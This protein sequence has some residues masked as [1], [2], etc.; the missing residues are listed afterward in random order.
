MFARR[1]ETIIK[2]LVGGWNFIIRRKSL[3]AMVVFFL[4]TNFLMSIFDVIIT[5]LI[6]SFS[7]PSTLGIIN[8]FSGIGVLCGSIIML[9]TGG[10]RKRAKGMVGFVIPVSFAMMIAALRPLPAFDA[11]ALLCFSL[12][13]T[14]VNIHWQSLIQVKVGLELQ[15]R[16]FAINQMMVSGDIIIKDKDKL[17]A[18]EDEKIQVTSYSGVEK[19]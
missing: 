16:V 7:N 13:L 17:Q 18:M 4:G 2:E 8:S 3:V 1:E 5:P 19:M 12:F 14:M 6:L 15:G 11:I 9:I 10:T